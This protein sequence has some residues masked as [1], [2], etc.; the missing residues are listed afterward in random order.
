MTVNGFSAIESAFSAT[1]SCFLIKNPRNII[2][3]T[4]AA[5]SDKNMEMS[6]LFI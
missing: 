6:P 3:G 4:G 2:R 1:A 5:D